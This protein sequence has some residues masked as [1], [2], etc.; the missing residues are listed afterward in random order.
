MEAARS[1]AD[2]RRKAWLPWALLAGVGGGGG[3]RR[4]DGLPV[5]LGAAG[6]QRPARG[7]GAG[8]RGPGGGAPVAA[9]QHGAP[10]EGAGAA[11][12]GH[13]PPSARARLEEGAR[14]GRAVRPA[15]GRPAGAGEEAEGGAG[16]GRRVARHLPPRV[17][18]RRA[19]R[20]APLRIRPVHAAAQGP[21][22]AHARGCGAGLGGGACGAGVLA[23]GRAALRSGRGGHGDELGAVVREGHLG[24]PRAARGA[25]RGWLPSG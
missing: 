1:A 13:A 6:A 9:R 23:H 12:D 2:W 15:R 21:G 20:A 3:G 8:V 16:P 17:P 19:L 22:S 14:G 25:G 24:G 7:A 18:A 4:G 10:A 11:A 5:G